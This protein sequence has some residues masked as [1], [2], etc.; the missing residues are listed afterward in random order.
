MGRIGGLSVSADGKRLIFWRV[1]TFPQA[2]LTEMDAETRR[3]RTPR[4]LTLDEN[5]NAA[6]AWTPDSRAVLFA[7]N[8]SGTYKLFRQPIDQVVPQ[9][10]V[11]GRSIFLPRLNPDGTQILYL[12]GFNS[13]DTAIPQSVM[14]VPLQGGSPRVV[15]QRPF[16]TNFQCARSPSKLCLVDRLEGST[17][18]FFSFDPEDGETRG[19]ASFQVVGNSFGWSLSPD[20]SKLALILGGPEHRVTFMTVSDRS[21]HEVELKQWPIENIDWAADGKS[22]FVASRNA[23][24]APV[25][26]GV[27]PNGDYRELLGGDGFTQYLWA[28]PSPDGRYIALE[29]V[30]GA[31]N[32]WMVEN[33]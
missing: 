8:R 5:E 28:V 26:F 14:R 9:V 30:T 6:T 17:M 24:G 2:F 32:V 22:V 4:R 16:I 25:I 13:R 31:N 20:G 11:E 10:L 27:E 18:Q 15:L 33:F 23:S 19:F 1:N 7:S 3:L 29:V 12:A 21:T